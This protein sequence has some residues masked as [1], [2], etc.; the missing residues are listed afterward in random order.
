[1]TCDPIVRNLWTVE[2]SSAGAN[3][4]GTE[5]INAALWSLQLIETTFNAHY[6]EIMVFNHF[7][8]IIF[9]N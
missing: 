7:L 4:K 6:D 1:M 3:T 2:L 9:A 5:G 8:P